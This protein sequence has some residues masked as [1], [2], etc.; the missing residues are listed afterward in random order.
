M[1]ISLLQL[2][3]FNI[4][5]YCAH[6][7]HSLPSCWAK[8]DS[9]VWKRKT[10]YSSYI[11][12]FHNFT[13]A[14]FQNQHD[15]GVTIKLVIMYLILQILLYVQRKKKGK[16]MLVLVK[17]VCLLQNVLKFYISLILYLL[18]FLLCFNLLFTYFSPPIII[19]IFLSPNHICICTSLH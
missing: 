10:K 11:M 13:T 8:I 17:S 1:N 14:N 2:R 5:N 12:N 18:S 19:T 6:L 15:H 9:L 16:Y 7:L 4:M 3:T